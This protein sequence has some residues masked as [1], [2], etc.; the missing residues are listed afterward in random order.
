MNL[1]EE[2]HEAALKV[3]SFYGHG[4]AARLMREAAE[5]LRELLQ[6]RDSVVLTLRTI[7]SKH[8]A[9]IVALPPADLERIEDAIFWKVEVPVEDVAKKGEE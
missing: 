2:L 6:Q 4:V 5:K 9:G 8:G 1:V 3:E 7:R